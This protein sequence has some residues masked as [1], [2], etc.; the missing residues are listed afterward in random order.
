ME[1]MQNMTD[2]LDTMTASVQLGSIAGLIN[3]SVDYTADDGNTTTGTVDKVN[4]VDGKII[5]N[6]GE[7]EVSM[8]NVLSIS[9]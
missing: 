7:E 6:I 9:N 5:L 3:K 4:L 1:Q 8:D 2:S